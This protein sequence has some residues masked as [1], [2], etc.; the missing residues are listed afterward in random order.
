VLIWRWSWRLQPSPSWT[1]LQ[2]SRLQPLASMTTLWRPSTICLHAKTHSFFLQT[3]HQ[4]AGYRVWKWELYF[5]QNCMP[6]VLHNQR[7]PNFHHSLWLMTNTYMYCGLLGYDNMLSDW[8]LP[9]FHRNTLLPSSVW[10]CSKILAT[11]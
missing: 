8:C 3:A 4:L 10:K 7:N 9:A 11:T 2:Q 1:K 6:S 5:Q